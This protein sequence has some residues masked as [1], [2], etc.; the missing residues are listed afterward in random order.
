MPKIDIEIGL[1]AGIEQALFDGVGDDAL[2][3]GHAGVLRGGAAA[4][5]FDD[6][7]GAE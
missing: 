7:E 6:Q 5:L 1:A 3:G 2:E 4:H